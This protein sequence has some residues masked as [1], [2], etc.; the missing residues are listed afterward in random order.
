M[1]RNIRDSKNKKNTENTKQDDIRHHVRQ[2]L[3]AETDEE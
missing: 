1:E 3:T 2:H